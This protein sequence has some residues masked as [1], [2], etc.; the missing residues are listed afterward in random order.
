MYGGGGITPDEKI[1][2]RSRTIAL[3][4]SLLQHYAFFNFTKH[5]FATHSVSKDLTVDDAIL[6]E[7]KTFLKEQKIEVTQKDLHRE[8]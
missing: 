4:D 5:Y 7:F 6:G 2:R 3:Q 8:S 1:D